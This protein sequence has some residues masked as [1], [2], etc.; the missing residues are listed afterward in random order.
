MTGY[1]CLLEGPVIHHFAPL[2]T[3]VDDPDYGRR[4]IETVISFRVF[5]GE[6][7]PK[8][9]LPSGNNSKASPTSD[10]RARGDNNVVACIVRTMMP[11]EA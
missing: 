4:S 3:H 10:T 2:Q 5:V 6:P 7:S 9:R 8:K 11:S 1:T